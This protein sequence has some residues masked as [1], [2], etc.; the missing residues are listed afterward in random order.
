M[1]EGVKLIYL[2]ALI[3][4]FCC[5]SGHPGR[6]REQWEHARGRF[7]QIYADPVGADELVTEP[8]CPGPW[9]ITVLGTDTGENRALCP[10]LIEVD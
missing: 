1:G 8:L 4:P 7:I 2:W 10:H 6:S 5:C 9:W 3:V